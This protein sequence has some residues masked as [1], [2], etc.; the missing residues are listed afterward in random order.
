MPTGPSIVLAQIKLPIAD[1]ESPSSFVF[2]KE[3]KGE[4]H[5]DAYAPAKVNIVHKVNPTVNPDYLV[6]N[7][8]VNP[9]DLKDLAVLRKK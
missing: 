4:T 1:P 6:H 2:D 7:G 3:N 9:N 8:R 5:K